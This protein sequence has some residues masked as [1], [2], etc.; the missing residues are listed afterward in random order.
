[1]YWIKSSNDRRVRIIKRRE[2]MR[3]RQNTE[4]VAA[5]QDKYLSTDTTLAS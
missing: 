3:Y 5:E 1:L 4:D 2:E